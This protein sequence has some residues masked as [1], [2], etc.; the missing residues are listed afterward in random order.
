MSIRIIYDA[1]CH[2][3][4]LTEGGEKS[5][6]IHDN[7]PSWVKDAY[8]YIDMI[9]KAIKEKLKE[10]KWSVKKLHNET[11]IRY[12]TLTDFINLGKGISIDNLEI[13]LTTLNLSVQ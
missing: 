2:D 8:K 5:P 6:S 1:L 10:L 3:G 12:N 11:E 9:R 13:V 7:E 4:W